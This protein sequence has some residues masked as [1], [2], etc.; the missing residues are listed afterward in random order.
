MNQS[1]SKV[2]FKALALFAI[3]QFLVACSDPKEVLISSDPT[4]W[5]KNKEMQAAI[6]K[7]SD[8]DRYCLNMVLRDLS[9]NWGKFG[10]NTIQYG[11]IREWLEYYGNC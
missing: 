2:S 7:L 8:D 3:F 5:K 4:S 11:K 6:E 9:N 10:K 1:I